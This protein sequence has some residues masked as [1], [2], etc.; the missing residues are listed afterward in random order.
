M[1]TNISGSTG[2]DKIQDG[3]VTDADIDTVAATKL[4]GTIADARFPATLPAASA[5][6]LTAIPAANITGTLPAISGANLTGI[7]ATVAALTDA[8]VS[9]SDPAADTN[10]S[11]TGHLW[12]NKTS[13]ECY[14]CIDITTDDNEWK[15]IG[16]GTGT[17]GGWVAYNVDYLIVGGGGAG[18]VGQAGGGGAGGFRTDTGITLADV[19]YTI[20]VGAGG[21]TSGTGGQAGGNGSASA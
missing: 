21:T 19:V 11:A 9:A 6:N 8:T 7:A 4:T 13:G 16:D 2:I 5:T 12:I 20:T 17:V 1:P 14:V 18:G 10:P 15:N 3:T